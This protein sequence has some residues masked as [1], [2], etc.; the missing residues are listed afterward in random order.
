MN[1]LNN[2]PKGWELKKLGE[3]AKLIS[4]F[5]FKSEL[6]NEKK[7]G[8]PLIRIRNLPNSSSE[9]YY[10]GDYKE[11]YV[12]NN[13]EF[14]IGM[15]GEF[16]IYEWRGV[17]SLLNQ[18]VCK[19][20]NFSN[21]IIPRYIY[22]LIREN[23]QII[24]DRTPFVTV[25]HISAKK[26]SDIELPVPSL[27]IQKQIVVILERAEKLRQRRERL[28]EETNKV[29][30]SIFASTF[31]ENVNIQNLGEVTEVIMGQSP[32]SN[33][34]NEQGNGLPFFQGKSEFRNKYPVIEK[35]CSNPLKLAKKDDVL[36]SVRAPVGPV[37]MATVDCCM[38]RGLCA[39]RASDKILADYLFEF[40]KMNEKII[41]ARGQGSTFKAINRK[42]I[43]N[44]RIPVPPIKLQEEFAKIVEKVEKTKAYQEKSTQEVNALFDALMQKAF[45]GEL[46]T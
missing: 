46:V 2:L 42:Q 6:F 23:L 11:D 40:L 41:E 18:R 15:D 16:K 30:Q 38:G 12:V 21:L 35:Y 26:I 10:N 3:V 5:A 13:G 9:T 29:L 24:E 28:K 31:G 17:K 19:L 14:L 4:G 20:T 7:K 43:E 39:I 22:Y 32:P 37:N 33:T 34:Y 27:E 25:K 36:M 44:I 45:T 1:S 8:I